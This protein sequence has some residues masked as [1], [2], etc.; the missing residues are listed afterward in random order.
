[1]ANLSEMPLPKLFFA[2]FAAL[3]EIDFDLFGLGI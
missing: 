2:F 1:M 3:R